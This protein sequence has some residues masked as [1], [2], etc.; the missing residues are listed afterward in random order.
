MSIASNIRSPCSNLQ[1]VYCIGILCTDYRLLIII[2]S[3]VGGVFLLVTMLL[4][5]VVIVVVIRR[6]E[7]RSKTYK[8]G[9]CMYCV[10][11]VYVF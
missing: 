11:C 2:F 3:A 6:K 1:L 10:R 8:G 9:L 5:V 4:M 7:K